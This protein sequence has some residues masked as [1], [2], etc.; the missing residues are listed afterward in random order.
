LLP[1]PATAAY[2]DLLGV[3]STK[4]GAAL[5]LEVGKRLTEN[6][7]AFAAAEARLTEVKGEA[8]VRLKF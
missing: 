3:F 8:G 4:T 2:L 6:I 5:R 7:A 1:T